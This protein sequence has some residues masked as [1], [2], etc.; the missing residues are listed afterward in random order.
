MV[1]KHHGYAFDLDNPVTF[2]EKVLWYMCEYYGSEI[3]NITDK[4]KFKFYI[5]AKLG[6]E[7]TIPMHGYWENVA[8]FQK[9][10]DRLPKSFVLKSNMQGSGNCIKI[11]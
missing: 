1:Q 4:V 3:S 8:K 11:I 10:W 7:K 2:T 6:G 5:D 9:E